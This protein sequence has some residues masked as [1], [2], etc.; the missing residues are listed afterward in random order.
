MR[1]AFTTDA[2]WPRINGVTVS[3]QTFLDELT[4]R[5]HALN[6]WAPTY[7]LTPEERAKPVYGDPRYHRMKSFGVA[8][9]KED[10]LT[11]PF[12]MKRFTREM[13]A[14]APDLIHCQTEFSLA[15]FAR[16]Y[17]KLRR[18]PLVMSCHTYFE[19][20]I[21]YFLPFLNVRFAKWFAR[22]ITRFLFWHAE[23]IITP[24][25]A[26]KAVLQSYGLRC[27]IHVI[28][29]GIRAEDFAGVSKERRDEDP[30]L[31]AHPELQGRRLLLAVGRLG[32]EKNV[33]FLLKVVQNLQTDHANTTLLVAG[34]GPYMDQ[35]KKNIHAM[36]LDKVVR[37]LGYVRRSELK[38]LYALADV[39]T[40]A[41]VTETQ[42]LVTLEAMMCHTP[43]VAIGKMGTKEVMQGDNGGFMV[44]EDV[45]EFADRVRQLLDD[46][47]LYRS[48]CA[49]AWEYSQNWT[50]SKMAER[51]ETLYRGLLKKA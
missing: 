32:Q 24:T 42:G 30:F 50:A 8:V 48:K 21:E 31:K 26:M 17:A 38:H 44:S 41:S 12:E 49:E 34:N 15:W 47:E 2:F 11:S 35:F 3:T 25:Q 29:T 37:C 22:E 6:L 36:G 19:Q 28:P 18:I 10:Y 20:Y 4:R 16:P 39:F 45:Q 43:V 14:F 9:S 1:I 23:T 51:L 46:P 7:P 13:N 5:G 27:P 40:F 33:D